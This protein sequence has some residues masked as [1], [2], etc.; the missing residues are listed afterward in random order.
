MQQ[1][2]M[3]GEEI[4]IKCYC[5]KCG[6]ETAVNKLTRVIEYDYACDL[7]G[8]KLVG[9][10][11]AEHDLC[12]ECYEKY[13]KLNI[14]IGDF[15]AMSDEEIELALYTFKVGDQVITADGRVGTI[16]DICTCEKC[17]ERGFYEPKVTT[18]IGVYNI[19]ITDTD[20]NNGF[21]SYYKI[22]DRVFGN[23]DEK[24][25]RRLEED[26]YTRKREIIKL[27]AQLNVLKELKEEKENATT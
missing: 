8:N 22:G 5:D 3:I 1:N 14:D 15:M 19:W 9:F 2:R 16:T 27:E 24:E 7:R 26:I 12:E 20:K 4:M 18:E 17:K 6:I 21:I 13:K 11:K 25:E 23:I 10:P